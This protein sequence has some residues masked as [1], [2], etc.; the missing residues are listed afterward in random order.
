MTIFPCALY[1]LPLES[2]PAST[3]H[4]SPFPSTEGHRDGASTASAPNLL[5]C[6]PLSPHRSCFPVGHY[7]HT[8]AASPSTTTSAPELLPRRPLP[9]HQ[10]CFPVV[11]Y[12]R[13]GA[14]FPSSTTS[15]PELLP[16]RPLP[17]H[18]SCFPVGHYL[19]TRAA[20]PSSTTSSLDLLHRRS[21][22]AHW[23]CFPVGHYL[24]TGA[25]P[26][27]GQYLR[28]VATPMINH[29]RSRYAKSILFAQS[30]RSSSSSSRD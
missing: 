23:I 24:H 19:R 29:G 2:V 21:V 11:H 9:P 17:R 8:I 4:L 15:A 20:P 10:I 14:A 13:T 1:Q 5:S 25:A 26:S 16:H 30:F 3:S 22:L 12:L 28:R 27:V 7:L 18:Q 6:R